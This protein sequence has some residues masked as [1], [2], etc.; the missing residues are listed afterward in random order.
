MKDANTILDQARK[1][2]RSTTSWADF[3]NALFDPVSG[4]ITTAYSTRV[5]REAFLRTEQYK[6]I[7]QLLSSA[8]DRYGLVEGATPAKSGRFVVRLPRSLHAALEHE[9]DREHVSLNQL[10]VAKLAAQLNVLRGS[11]IMRTFSTPHA[12]PPRMGIDM[13]RISSMSPNAPNA[14]NATRALS[15]S[16]GPRTSRMKVCSVA[17]S[18]TAMTLLMHRPPAVDVLLPEFT[19][20]V[21]L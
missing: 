7:R 12:W 9:A 15:H 20:I 3:A 18:T 2:A 16:Q 6:K 1:I 10:V 11:V 14:P 5:E 4:L 17:P 13:R 21:V 8:I 19:Q